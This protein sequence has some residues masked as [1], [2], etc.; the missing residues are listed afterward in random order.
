MFSSRAQILVLFQRSVDSETNRTKDGRKTSPE[1]GRR[2]DEGSL[3]E[4]GKLSEDVSGNNPISLDNE[5][6]DNADNYLFQVFMIFR[7]A[8][9][10]FC[11]LF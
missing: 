9:N 7:F 2:G 5:S 3:K 11:K 6:P 10:R 8:L 4:D 1:G